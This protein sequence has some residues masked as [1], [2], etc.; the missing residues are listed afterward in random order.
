MSKLCPLALVVINYN[1]II[2]FPNVDKEK[3]K[4]HNVEQLT[5]AVRNDKI[6]CGPICPKVE[7]RYEDMSLKKLLIH[8]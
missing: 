4:F 7:Y 3:K 1:N 8:R 2:T 6:C 5:L